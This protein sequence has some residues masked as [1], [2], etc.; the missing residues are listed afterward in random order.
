MQPATASPFT[1]LPHLSVLQASGP[2]AATFL[3]G[4]L[5]QDVLGLSA[6]EARLG[7][8]CSAKGRL[9]ASFVLLRPQP[10][11]VWL[12]VSA[13]LAEALCKRLRMF[14][15]RAQCRL[16]PMPWPVWGAWSSELPAYRA[17]VT[18]ASEGALASVHVGWPGGRQLRVGPG[19]PADGPAM[20]NGEATLAWRQADIE[21]GLPWIEAA[22]VDRFVPQMVNLELLGGV[23]F[24][25]GCYPGQEVVA[26]SQYR[27]TLKRRTAWFETTSP[28]QPGQELVHS[29]DPGQ[30]S[31]TVVNCVQRQ[32]L[33]QALVE[34][35]LS[36]L[37]DPHGHWTPALQARTLPYAWPTEAEAN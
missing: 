28:L 17:A 5:T 36:A 15:L 20:A 27:G 26:R 29:S 3:Q 2:D 1:P 19:G 14:V 7:G 32:G 22:T 35:K 16:E 8:F 11:T 10:D 9:Q 30:P 24:R 12:L 33:T 23:N 13:D 25:K 31:G 18:A 4:Q 6:D 37:N 21:C 34:V